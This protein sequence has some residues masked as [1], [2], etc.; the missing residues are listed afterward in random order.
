MHAAKHSKDHAE[1]TGQ[2]TGLAPVSTGRLHMPV[3]DKSG[4][5][6]RNPSPEASPASSSTAS[7]S[8]KI[9]G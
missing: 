8:F 6:T 2:E 4:M 3:D 9:S 7:K 1:N 5:V